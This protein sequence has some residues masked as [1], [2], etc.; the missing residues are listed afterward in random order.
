MLPKQAWVSKN[1]EILQQVLCLQPLEVGKVIRM[2]LNKSFEIFH[3]I[4][5]DLYT[6]SEKLLA[7]EAVL[8]FPTHNSVTKA[9]FIN[10][11]KWFMKNCVEETN[12]PQTNY[13][14]IRAM[15]VDEMKDFLM[16]WF[17]DCMSGKAPTN[18]KAWLES[19]VQEE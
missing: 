10:V 5:S 18:V 9:T 2:S 19:G 7:I 16:K 4:D 17:I 8:D 14:R 13:D 11:L 6:E 1:I 15:S 3:N 12:K